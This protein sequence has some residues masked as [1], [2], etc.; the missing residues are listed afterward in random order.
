MVMSLYVENVDA[1]YSRAVAAGATV[2]YP[3]ANQFDG[4]RSARVADPFG[5]VGILATYLEEVSPEE[6]QRRLEAGG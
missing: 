2:V 3:L 5:H 4:D 1:V 6:Q